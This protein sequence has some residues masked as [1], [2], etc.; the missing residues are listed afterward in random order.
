MARRRFRDSVTVVISP[1]ASLAASG[2]GLKIMRDTAT[3]ENAGSASCCG[4]GLATSPTNV[5]NNLAAGTWNIASDSVIS[6]TA[7]TLTLNNAGTLR[8]SVGSAEV[9][10]FGAMPVNNS[11]L[12]EAL[13]GELRLGDF[14]QSSG[15][16]SLASSSLTGG[17]YAIQGGDVS[18]SGAIGDT[19]ND[20]AFNPGSPFGVVSVLGNYTQTANGSLNVDIGGVTPGFDFD[21]VNV[22]GAAE[23][24]GALNVNLGG[25]SPLLGQFFVILTYDRVVGSFP[26]VNGLEIGGGLRFQLEVGATEAS[27]TVVPSL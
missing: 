8:K 5:W 26:T 27:L 3:L 19:V 20:G 9:A 18:G 1:T 16:I 12:V 21:Q 2:A 23:L 11:G 24:D 4:F 22:S 6:R 10:D 7:A 25:F 17:P 14:V 15:S 13:S